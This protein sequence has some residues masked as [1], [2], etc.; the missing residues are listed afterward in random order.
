M[1][2]EGVE[3]FRSSERSTLAL[4]KVSKTFPGQ[5][6]LIDVSLQV[7]AGEV[8]CLLGQNGSG[9]STL[10]KVLAGYHQPDPGSTGGFD[11]VDIDLTHPGGEWR[12]R[13]RIIHQ[14]LGLVPGLSVVEN[15]ALGRGFHTGRFG[16]INWRAE[17]ER[18]RSLLRGFGLSVDVCQPVSMLSA[19][20]K[21]MVAIARAMQDWHD[22]RFG[23]LVLDEPTAS[24]PS[25]EVD[26]LF[27]MIE[28]IVARG[29][30]VIF[31]SHRLDEVLRIGDRVSVLRDGR[32]VA[33]EPVAGLTHDRLVELIVGRR[34]DELYTAPPPQGKEVVMSV[35]ALA[36]KSVRE[37]SFE[38]HRG[39]IIGFAGLVGSGR[40]DI[41]PLIFGA[42]SRSGGSVSL[43]GATIPSDDPRAALSAGLALVPGDRAAAGVIGSLSVRENL[44][45][46]ALGPLHRGLRHLWW[47]DRADE[48]VD[49]RQWATKLDVRP[50]DPDRRV[51]T[52]SGGNQ[53]KVVLA[54]WLRTSPTVL[55]L[56]EP[57]QGV[58][59]G[60]KAE[61]YRAL[62]AA[63]AEGLAIVL[64]SSDAAEL[65]NV[66]D[67]V[68]VMHR[69]VIGSHL[70]GGDLTEERI[71]T[72]TLRAEP[73]PQGTPS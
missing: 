3:P 31:V 9:K 14:D 42:V 54:K 34:V 70:H 10:I 11:G 19:A 61:I 46:P 41:A 13:I 37:L 16:L 40:E 25:R 72:E 62:A 55:L 53:Q 67:R 1:S 27:R 12:D 64:A 32:L 6:A 43:R 30:G 18:A 73:I 26:G 44:T 38:L 51:E 17:T 57:T 23:V 21:S 52:L 45:L 22:D 69:G 5:R 39:E 60:A 7:C 47:I 24:L 33:T 28:R 4:T 65:A 68:L 48:N 2:S 36:G 59:V 63:A 50:N 29:A 71:A 66:C 15:L 58:D 20:E 8:H 49:A 35:A 56:D